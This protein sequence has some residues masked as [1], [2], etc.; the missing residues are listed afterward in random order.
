M[1]L[2]QKVFYNFDLIKETVILNAN[3]SKLDELAS[4]MHRQGE[5]SWTM[6]INW[7]DS[8]LKQMKPIRPFRSQHKKKNQNF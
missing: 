7:L 2:F 3:T 1:K 6:P 5:V 4:Q 8:L